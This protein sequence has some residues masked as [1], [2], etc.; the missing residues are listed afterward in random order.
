[1]QSLYGE[2]W[3]AE[4]CFR[5]LKHTLRMDVLKCKTPD[6][7]QKELLIYGIAYNHVRAIMVQAGINQG[8]P[9]NRI[10]LIDVVRRIMLGP[11]DYGN[12]PRFKVNPNR[13]GR[14]EPRVKKR[15]DKSYKLMTKP[16]W[17]Y[18]KDM[19]LLAL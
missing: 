13:A 19:R 9:P 2:R 6:G 14:V 1:M 17:M 7:V 10:S 11:L 8:V 4:T 15:R 16:R 3:E 12:L 18:H 5:H